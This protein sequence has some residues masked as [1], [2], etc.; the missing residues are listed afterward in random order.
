V[1]RSRWGDANFRNDYFSWAFLRLMIP[2]PLQTCLDF[3]STTQWSSPVCPF[4]SKGNGSPEVWQTW[5][6]LG[7]PSWEALN[8]PQL[9]VCWAFACPSERFWSV[10][11]KRSQ[12]SGTILLKTYVWVAWVGW[13]GMAMVVGTAT[14]LRTSVMGS[15]MKNMQFCTEF[16]PVV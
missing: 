5:L 2:W 7:Y 13:N 10:L 9:E 12:R 1:V 15:L 14:R 4:H 3:H 8:E 11:G 16:W 6:Q